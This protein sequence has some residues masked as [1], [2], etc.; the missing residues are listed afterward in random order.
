MANLIQIAEELE[1]MP[2]D[3]LAQMTQDPNST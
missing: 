1:Y 2:K 3:Q